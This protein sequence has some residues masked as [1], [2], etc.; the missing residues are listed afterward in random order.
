MNDSCM[1][2][3]WEKGHIEF[4]QQT[5][6]KVIWVEKLITLRLKI[7]HFY[8]TV[9]VVIFLWNYDGINIAPGLVFISIV[10]LRLSFFFNSLPVHLYM[11]AKLK[12][13]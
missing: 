9:K 2:F 1:A 8:S 6:E 5:I 3:F 10:L 11:S 12:R 13:R 7:L 4:W